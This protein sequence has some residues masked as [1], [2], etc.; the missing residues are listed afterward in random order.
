MTLDDALNALKAKAQPGRDAEMAAYH[1]VDR[2]YLG[3][4]NPDTND[5]VKTW[6]Q[7]LDVA[8]RLPLAKALWDTNIYE[9]RL[10]AAK[11]FTQ[12]R[13]RPDDEIWAL[14]V[15]WVPDFDSW[16]I[17]DHVAM[18]GQKRLMADPSRL[19]E[20]ETWTTSDQFW[21]RRAA[22]VFT[23]PWTKQNFPKPAEL[24]ARDRILG[25]AASYVDDPEWFIQKAV[26]WW[27]RDLSRHDPDRVIAF[28]EQYG[29]RMK[30]FA[31]KEAARHLVNIGRA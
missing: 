14:L 3:V 22:L 26:A 4:A 6:R 31:Q 25:W 30:P 2:P 16:A 5:L 7:S 13:M 23:L 21:T 11:L 29:S 12:A 18:A 19:D 10:A 17:A 20:V 28:L 1:K 27:L 24:V 8:A 9:A 15:R